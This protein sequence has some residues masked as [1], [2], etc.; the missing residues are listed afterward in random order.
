VVECEFEGER[1]TERKYWVTAGDVS[2]VRT[3]VERMKPLSEWNKPLTRLDFLLAMI[4][5]FLGKFIVMWWY[6]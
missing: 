2:N 6:L 3:G 1:K 4:G 5:W